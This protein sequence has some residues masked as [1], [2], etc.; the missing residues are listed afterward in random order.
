VKV[1]LT[2]VGIVFLTLLARLRIFGRSV[3]IVLYLV[4]AG[5]GALVAYELFLL[6]NIPLD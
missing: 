1:G 5:Y 2:A 6:R 3:G 4:L